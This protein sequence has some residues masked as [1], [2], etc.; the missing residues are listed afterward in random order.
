MRGVLPNEVE[1][2]SVLGQLLYDGRGPDLMINC[3]STRL[4]VVHTEII[5]CPYVVRAS[6]TGCFYRTMSNCSLLE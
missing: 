5:A 3:L 1:K 4:Y 2:Q 6:A